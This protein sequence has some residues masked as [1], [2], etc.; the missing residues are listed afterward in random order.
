MAQ[1][2]MNTKQEALPQAFD[3]GEMRDLT[4]EELEEVAGG[5]EVQNDGPPT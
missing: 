2:T 1:R 4:L 3:L 5:P